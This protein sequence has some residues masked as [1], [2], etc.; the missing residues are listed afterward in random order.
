MFDLMRW[1][2]R[3]ISIV[4][5]VDESYRSKPVLFLECSEAGFW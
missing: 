2:H 5:A 4:A 3:V 1:E